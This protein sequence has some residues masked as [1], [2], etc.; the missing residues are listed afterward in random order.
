MVL[1]FIF[2]VQNYYKFSEKSRKN[3][4]KNFGGV[5]G[6]G[7]GV[8]GGWR[9]RAAVAFGRRLRAVGKNLRCNW[10]VGLQRRGSCFIDL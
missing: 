8:G 6:L 7:G 1:A 2:R 9:V 4:K 10:I 5:G 3:G